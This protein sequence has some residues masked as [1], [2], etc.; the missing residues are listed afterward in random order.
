[1]ILHLRQ[2]TQLDCLQ[3]FPTETYH[4]FERHGLTLWP[5]WPLETQTIPCLCL[6]NA[7]ITRSESAYLAGVSSLKSKHGAGWGVANPSFHPQTWCQRQTVLE[8]QKL[9][10]KCEVRLQETVSQAK[11]NKPLAKPAQGPGFDLHSFS[12][13]PASFPQPPTHGGCVQVK[14]GP[15]ER[16]FPLTSASHSHEV[17]GVTFLVWAGSWGCS[18]L[19]CPQSVSPPPPAGR[20]STCRPEFT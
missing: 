3:P 16:S 6:P 19:S 11:Q 2:Q 14:K 10:V 17:A 15:C 4:L 13:I 18:L 12:S 5:T 8:D 20:A 9:K 1:M 7:G